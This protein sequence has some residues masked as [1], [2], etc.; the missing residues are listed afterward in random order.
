MS[1]MKATHDYTASQPDE[2]S[3]RA[4]SLIAIKR[5]INE[6]WS[7]GRIGQRSGIFPV[8]FAEPAPSPTKSPAQ[9]APQIAPVSRRHS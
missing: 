1:L 4:G 7:E 3:F 9:A 6:E 8:C 2:L 5:K